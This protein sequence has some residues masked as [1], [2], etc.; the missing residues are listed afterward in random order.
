V[1]PL[2]E[3]D[4]ILTSGK[5][6]GGEGIWAE[7]DA[8]VQAEKKSDLQQSMYVAAQ[9]EPDRHAEVLKLSQKYNVA[10]E[11][12]DRNYD[13][14][15][16]KEQAEALNAD[17]LDDTPTVAEFLRDPNNAILAKDD[18]GNLTQAE[19]HVQKRE[20]STRLHDALGKGLANFY[21]GI[22]RSPNY[23]AS[24]IYWPQNQIADKFDIPSLKVQ[25]QPADNSL[26]RYYDQAAESFS[27]EDLSGSVYDELSKGNWKEAAAQA[28]IGVVESSPQ[29]IAMMMGGMGGMTKGAALASGTTTAAQKQKEYIDQGMDPDTATAVAGGYGAIE[30]LGERIGG[31]A[32]FQKWEK[33]ITKQYGKEVSRQFFK[34]MGKTLAFSA[35]V[36]SIEE[37]ATSLGQDSLENSTGVNEVPLTWAEMGKHA[38]D[39]MAIGGISGGLI[40]SPGAAMRARQTAHMAKQAEIDKNFYLSMQNTAEASLLRQRLPEAKRK[41]VEQLVQGSPV[42]NIYIDP[43]AIDEFFQS[44]T[45]DPVAIMQQLGFLDQYTAAKEHGGQVEIPL[46]TWVD[47]VVGTEYYQGLANDVKFDPAGMSVNEAKQA[48]EELKAEV[49][50]EAKKASEAKDPAEPEVDPMKQIEEEVLGQLASTDISEQEAKLYAQVVSSPFQVWGKETGQNPYELFKAYN[51]RIKQYADQM[52]VQ[53]GETAL[54]QGDVKPVANFKFSS[55]PDLTPEQQDVEAR[56][57]ASLSQPDVEERYSA[58]PDS[59]GGKIIDADLVRHLAPEYAKDRDGRVLHTASTHGPASA[60]AWEL[61]TRRLAKP[62]QG[63]GE[64]FLTSGGGGSGKSTVMSGDERVAVERAEIVYDS[65][66]PNLEDAIE[67]VQVALRTGRPVTIVH[68]YQPLPKALDQVV[69]RFIKSGRTI[70]AKKLVEDHIK[71]QETFLD[72]AKYFKG[73]PGVEFK[74]YDNS[75]E[76][77]KPISVAKLSTLKYTKDKTV[78]EAIAHY[79]P[80]AE[81]KLD[82]AEQEVKRHKET[83]RQRSLSNSPGA[84]GRTEGNP[85]ASGQTGTGEPGSGSEGS[86]GS[87]VSFDQSPVPPSSPAPAFYSRLIQTVEQ[88]MGGS[89]TVEQINGML[90]DIKPEERKWMGLDEFLKG[91]EKVSKTELLEFLR[92]H[93]VEIKEVVK[94][95]KTESHSVEQINDDEWAIV[96]KEGNLVQ[97]GFDSEEQAL[98]GLEGDLDVRAGGDTKFESYTLPGGENYR[99]VLFTLP[100]RAKQ[101][102]EDYM[103]EKHGDKF[104][105]MTDSQVKF[106]AKKYENEMALEANADAYRSS[107]YDEAN[108]LAHTRLK[109]RSDADGKRVLFVEEIQSDWHQAG[110][111]HGYKDPSVK[112]VSR[113]E[114]KQQ[115]EDF[116]KSLIDKYAPK[117]VKLSDFTYSKDVDI[118][119]RKG[120]D[121]ESPFNRIDT[122][123]VYHVKRPGKPKAYELWGKGGKDLGTFKTKKELEEALPE[124]YKQVISISDVA[125]DVTAEEQS[126]YAELTKQWNEAHNTTQEVPDA[127]FKKT[128]HEFVLKRIIREAAEK[129]YDRIAWTTGEQQA[130]RYDLSTKI[131]YVSY[132]T[133]TDFDD[134]VTGYKISAFRNGNNVMEK[135]AAPDELDDILGKEIAEKIRKGEGTENDRVHTPDGRA[136]VDSKIL[137]GL[138]LRVGGEGMKGFYDKMIPDF[139]NKF[140][141]KYGAKVGETKISGGAMSDTLDVDRF[142]GAYAIVKPD[143]QVYSDKNGDYLGYE[144]EDEARDVL[145]SLST[146]GTTVHSLDITPQLR[147]AALNE[148]FS[149]FQSGPNDPR[150]RIRFGK[151]GINIDLFKG[152]DRST[153]LHE[154]G[155]FYLQVMGELASTENAPEKLK[156]DL[157]T[158]L[159]WMGIQS[160]DEIKTEHHEQF[161]RGFEAYLFEGKAPSARLRKAFASFRAWLI[162]VYKSVTALQV[163]L[164]PEVRDVFDRMLATEEEIKEAKHSQNMK[165]MFSDPATSGMSPEMSEKYYKAIRE[166]EDA[167]IEALELKVMEPI[168]RAHE[169]DYKAQREKVRGEISVE[170]QNRPAYRALQK[171]RE[172]PDVKLDRKI[173]QDAYGKDVPKTLPRGIVAND[174][175]DPDVAAEMLGFDNGNDL[176]SA[177]ANLPDAEA[178]I[179]ELTD[180]EMRETHGDLLQEPELQDWAVKAL[181]NEKRSQIL[182]MELEHLAS[183]NMP[184]LKDAMKR[185]ARRLPPDQAIK[186]EAALTVAGTKVENLKPRLY[187]LAER[188]AAKEAGQALARGDINAAFDAKKRELLNFE[189]YRAAVKAKEEVESAL[190]RFKKI[191]KS[192][193]KL[194]KSRD[195]NLVNAARA[196]LASFGIGKTDKPPGAYLEAIRKFDP[197]TFAGI[198]ALVMAATERVAP[199]EELTYDEFTAMHDA[200]MAIWDLSKSTKEIEIDGQKYDR[201]EVISKLQEQMADKASPPEQK[202]SGNHTWQDK[203]TRALLGVRSALRRVESWVDS[204]DDGDPQGDFRKFVFQP[205]SD[206]VTRYRIAK[207]GM[208]KKYLANLEKITPTLT[209]QKIQ[210]PELGKVVFKDK[211]HLLGAMLH[212]GNQSNLEKL[213]RGYGWGSITPDGEIDTTNWNQFIQRMWAEKILT[214]VDYDFLQS[215]WDLLEEVKPEAQKV[216]KKLYGYYFNEI[217]AKEIQTPFGNYRGGYVPAVTDPLL[218]EDQAIRQEQELLEKNDNSFMFPTAGRGFTKSRVEAYAAPLAID[219]RRVGSHI[220]KVLRFVHIEPQVKAVGRIVMNKDFRKALSQ[221]DPTAGAD[222]LVPWLQRSAQQLVS[223]PSK[224]DGGKAADWFFSRLRANVG[225]QAMFANVVNAMQQVTGLSISTLKVKP[226][227]LRNA[228]WRYVRAPKETVE[229]ISEKSAFMRTR[230]D[231]QMQEMN[232]RIDEIV[233]NPGKFEK[234]RDF[235]VQHTYILQSM[236]Q[237]PVDAMTWAGAYDQALEHGAKEEEAVKEADAAVRQTQ[238]SMNAEDISRYES[239][240]PFMRAFT[241]FYSYFNMQANLLGTEFQKVYRDVGLKKGA[242]RMLFIYTMGFM[243]PAVIS[244][245]LVVGMSGRGFDDDDDDQYLDDFLGLFF[246]SQ[247]RAGT[248]LFPVVGPTLNA[249]VNRFNDKQWDDNIRVS[250]LVTTLENAAGAPKSIHQAVTT[251]EGKKAAIRDVLTLLGLVTGAP[252]APLSRPLGYAADVSEGKAQ[253]KG[254][255]DYTRG[256]ITGKSGAQR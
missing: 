247:F 142:E 100:A 10:P 158:I 236:M 36:E 162:Q 94:G 57:A 202:I 203:A 82:Y 83:S 105:D 44:S 37:G 213:L 216:H 196:I 87:P 252:V 74:A 47:K 226:K 106:Y 141:K 93:Q 157:K 32:I 204:M 184:V 185:V 214:Q 140:G 245:A 33:A 132:E 4:E 67:R 99:E 256:L 9:K 46:A 130:E 225:R 41:F 20:L 89:A 244:E 251:G 234:L 136:L 208:I 198:E 35:G 148:G 176:I 197:D 146:D 210:A 102:F 168:R 69:G 56:F 91:K 30:M 49:E 77:P 175:L 121:Y 122:L 253:P 239:G 126:K 115:L 125:K 107:H 96:D 165:P 190:D 177:M 27:H 230:F 29:T 5:V 11:F 128:W 223:I 71:S 246:G 116:E 250:P 241:M 34:E 80:E 143:G 163:N 181:H 43:N 186:Q 150:G 178:L 147:D 173:I 31:M 101:T 164:T 248:A 131:D 167:A 215:V 55:V 228:L 7:I 138:D 103:L 72:L 15:S 81:R 50:A 8:E 120:K 206:G 133:E 104:I 62:V 217:T 238:G 76:S 139:L 16:K 58:L 199:Y 97:G 18:I 53:Q 205:V 79:L 160:I 54:A 75:G 151:D 59:M 200:V 187:Q 180:K 224:G 249:G 240:S 12:A 45:T 113:Q 166:A 61:Y 65:V 73:T 26:T 84:P 233:L 209:H 98:G 78:D 154:L 156:E 68:V 88:K 63:S 111:K 211:A 119:T 207:A 221:V 92:G 3:A 28:L 70:P 24:A 194:A 149:L 135:E 227:H 231:S 86:E 183:E 19:R 64:V 171:L 112:Q 144:T 152:K 124:A 222:M 145:S 134:K 21:G 254:A 85:E 201:D 153:V 192:D 17:A 255:L 169:A 232:Q 195:M 182:R 14:L 179:D 1:S 114:A 218:V 127:P 219:L 161:A 137:E 123:T 191:N 42:E 38:F 66:M 235:G 52:G 172:H 6:A 22:L 155:H 109:D 118:V 23:L 40:T 51:L 60:F 95:T 242:S 220:D 159:D 243:I 212:S 25:V 110:R 13:E 129:G 39:S 229:A 170:V 108:I 174:G 90:R 2:N 193:E 237:N 48:R 189:L 117:V 188:K